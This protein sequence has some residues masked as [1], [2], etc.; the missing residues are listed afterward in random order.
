MQVPL[1]IT[2]FTQGAQFTS[3]VLF[4]A[5]SGLFDIDQYFARFILEPGSTLIDNQIAT[6]PVANLSVAANAIITQPLRLAMRMLCP[7]GAGAGYIRKKAIMA[8]LIN[9][10]NNH[11]AQGGTFNVATP[12]YLY[13]GLI[14]ESLKD[15]SPSV[16]NA[17]SQ[18][19]LEYLWSFMQPLISLDQVSSTLNSSM[20]AV[21]LG[22]QTF[23][24]PPLSEPLTNAIGFFSPPNAGALVPAASGVVGATV[25]PPASQ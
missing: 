20:E 18:V 4:G 2:S 14:L 21:R 16:S 6:Y 11:I 22:I 24:N 19:Q 23:G 5:T 9:T 8:G 3:G 15:V 7:A 25:A 17:N 1:P 13:T 10:L 12:A